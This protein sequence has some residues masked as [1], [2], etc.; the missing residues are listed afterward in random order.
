VRGLPRHPL[1]ASHIGVSWFPCHLLDASCIAVRI[2]HCYI[3]LSHFS[4]VQH[5]SRQRYPSLS[6]ECTRSLWWSSTLECSIS[7][8]HGNCLFNW[9][10]RSCCIRGFTGCI[11]LGAMASCCNIISIVLLYHHHQ[12]QDTSHP[13]CSIFM[14]FGFSIFS[15]VACISSASW[16]VLCSFHVLFPIAD[17][18]VNIER[19]YEIYSIFLSLCI[20]V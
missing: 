3:A 9:H 8:S 1:D 18:I 16:N 5:T 17:I 13:A 12:P 7:F 15:F 19:Y 20:V 14:G 4:N 11:L 6:L 10:S 2:F